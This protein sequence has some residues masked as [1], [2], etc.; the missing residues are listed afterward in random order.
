M[1]MAVIISENYPDNLP[2]CASYVV[3]GTKTRNSES[4]SASLLSSETNS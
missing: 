1:G 3:R 4:Q 2:A